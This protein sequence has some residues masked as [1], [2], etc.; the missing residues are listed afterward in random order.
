MRPPKLRA[1]ACQ[2]SGCSVRCGSAATSTLKSASSAG[3]AAPLLGI[4]TRKW[5]NRYGF[6]DCHAVVMM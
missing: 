4:A 3:G 1:A 5:F 6:K 2:A